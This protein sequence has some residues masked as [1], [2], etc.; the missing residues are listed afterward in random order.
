VGYTGTFVESFADVYGSEWGLSLGV[1]GEFHIQPRLGLLFRY[2][3]YSKSADGV[4]TDW[5]QSFVNAGIRVKGVGAG[6]SYSSVPG[7]SGTGVYVEFG[8]SGPGM[9]WFTKFDFV[10]ING[11]QAGALTFG[12]GFSIGG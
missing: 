1:E 9:T 5:T 11:A 8:D 7:A 6:L 2:Q 3:H 10:S 12:L 4:E